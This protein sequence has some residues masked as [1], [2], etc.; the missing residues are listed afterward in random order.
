MPDEQ[1]TDAER[2]IAV[3]QIQLAVARDEIEFDQLDD[4]F[5]AIYRADTKG[6]LEAVTADLP[7]PPAP[8]PVV[9]GHPTPP[10]AFALFGDIKQGGHLEVEGN[11]SYTTVFGDVTLDLSS[12][13][14]KDG[15]RIVTQ[16]VFG[17]VTII[18]P[19]GVRV[20]RQT[21]TIFGDLR[22]DLSPP[23]PEAATI[24]VVA[25][26]VF[27]NAKIYS[28]SRVPEGRLRTFW[29]AFRAR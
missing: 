28:L 15:T 14:L 23:L 8:L 12:T 29:K 10:S 13:R 27:G 20:S 3:H 4:R 11:V 24:H 26:S 16:T 9:L 22:E 5:G 2:D 6:E 18:L 7:V 17:S 1:V 21:L 25:R 19:D